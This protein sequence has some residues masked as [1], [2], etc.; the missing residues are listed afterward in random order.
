MTHT[1][2]TRRLGALDKKVVWHP[3]TQMSDWEAGDP[4]IIERGRGVYLFDTNGRKYIDGVSSLWV[5]VHGHRKK[6]LDR[7]L[8]RQLG[9]LA[10]STLLGLANV[11]SIELAQELVS[12]APEGLKRVFYSDNGSTAVEVA[13]KM[14]YQYWQH[15]NP[16]CSRKKFITFNEAYHGDT[17]GSV[18]VGGIEL[19]H[20]QFEPLL[21][22]VLR[23]PSP[24]CY[25]KSGQTGALLEMIERGVNEHSSELIGVVME[26][27]VQAAAGMLVHPAGFL[28]EIRELCN[29]HGLLLVLDEVATGFGRTGKMFACQHE[30]IVPDLMAVA[31][32]LTGGYL[33]LAATLVTEEIYHAFLGSYAE[34][35]TFFHGHT[36]TGNPLACAV[37]LASLKQFRR[38]RLLQHIHKQARGLARRL[39]ALRELPH[40]GEIR[41]AGL[42]AGIELVADRGKNLEYPLERKM[43]IRVCDRVRDYG[44]LLRPLGNVIV[45]MPPLAIDRK[46]L[47]MLV[48]ATYKGIRDITEG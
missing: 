16:G 47:D 14:A 44:V 18:S 5:N 28:Q 4:L 17:L 9:K 43:G 48:E 1:R 25:R 32:G 40:V 20:K 39:D 22:D 10:H 37:A 7:A 36:Y 24:Y 23:F 6:E 34:F 15:K 19:F 30:G 38:D 29:R 26:P 8:R 27:V 33:P 2:R 3:F 45:L 31:K 35:K 21:F 42:M 13:L 12:V 11:P 41:Q 46:E